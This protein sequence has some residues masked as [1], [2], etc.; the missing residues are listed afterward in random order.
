VNLFC[1]AALAP[2][3]NEARRLVQQ[4]GALVSHNGSLAPITDVNAL[5]GSDRLNAE[6]ELLIRAGKKRYCLIVTE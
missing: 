5:I 6:G 3:K 2:T 1:D 4:G